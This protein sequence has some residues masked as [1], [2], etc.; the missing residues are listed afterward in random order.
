MDYKKQICEYLNESGG[1]ITC[2]GCRVREIPS[3]YLTRMVRDKELTKVARGIYI[4]SSGD[5]DELLFLQYKYK[6]IIYSY[7]TALFLMGIGDKF[8]GKIEV[9]V[10]YSYKINNPKNMNINY[11]SDEMHNIGVVEAKTSFGNKVKIY[12][13]ERT[14][15]DFVKN[16]KNM[17]REVYIKM[18]KAY[19]EYK[20][21]DLN[22]LYIISKKMGIAD[23]VRNIVELLI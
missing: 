20:D 19:G 9:S 21:K 23:K 12:G 6:K 18:L 11:V 22:K 8:A 3:V 1:I 2:E 14:L 16:E 4:D 10:P 5:Y 15:C 13:F 7:E 17:D